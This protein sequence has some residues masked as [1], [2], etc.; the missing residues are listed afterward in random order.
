MADDR[1]G[2]GRPERSADP[3]RNVLGRVSEI[4]DSIL[5]QG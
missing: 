2:A 4:C 1:Y 3:C 5:E